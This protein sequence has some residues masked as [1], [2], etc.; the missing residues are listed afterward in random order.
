VQLVRGEG[1]PGATHLP[2]PVGLSKV[3]GVVQGVAELLLAESDLRVAGLA[4]GVR[5]TRVICSD[6]KQEDRENV[7]MC[8]CVCVCERER[9]RERERGGGLFITSSN[10]ERLDHQMH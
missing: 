9:E 2:R 4:D 8:V 3:K 7:C 1:R 10:T 6:Q 5:P